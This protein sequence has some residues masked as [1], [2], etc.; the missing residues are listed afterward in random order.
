MGCG[1][2]AAPR[3]GRVIGNGLI[4]ATRGRITVLDR[5]RLEEV[6][7]D[8]YGFSEAEYDRVMAEA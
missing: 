6:A 1:A 8:A 3:Q 2:E 5:T 4:R 7:D